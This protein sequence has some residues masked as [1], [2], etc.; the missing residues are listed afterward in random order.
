MNARRM[1]ATA[2]LLPAALAACATPESRIRQHRAEF[3]SYPPAVQKKIRA[4]EVDVGFTKEQ[5]AIALGRPDRMYRRRTAQGTHDVWAYMGPGGRT[6]VG[7]GFG[8]SSGGWDPR[9]GGG[10]GVTL[11]DDR[12]EDRLRVV[13]ENGVV[14]AVE[15]RRNL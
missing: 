2:F 11:E 9:L 10:M 7:F 3:E 15:D 5:V 4:G 12:V 8:M 14:V 13:F 1:L 6:A